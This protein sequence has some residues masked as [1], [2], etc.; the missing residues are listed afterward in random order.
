MFSMNMIEK[1]WIGMKWIKAHLLSPRSGPRGK[2]NDESLNQGNR[3]RIE[4]EEKAL[5][6]LNVVSG[7]R[8]WK[9]G[10]SH[11]DSSDPGDLVGS[12]VIAPHRKHGRAKIS[13]FQLSWVCSPV[14]W[15]SIICLLGIHVC[16]CK[17]R[18]CSY[19]LF[20]S[21]EDFLWV[22][23]QGQEAQWS[24]SVVTVSLISIVSLEPLHTQGQGSSTIHQPTQM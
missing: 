8:E 17:A 23:T 13:Q 18:L 1:T 6:K 7:E 24:P 16:I 11:S 22:K 3:S 12:N 20:W 10:K 14:R 4:R 19:K 2:K 15:Q 5:V 9:K 21:Q